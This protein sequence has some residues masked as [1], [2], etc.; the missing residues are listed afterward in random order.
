MRVIVDFHG[1]V[2][3]SLSHPSCISG[4]IVLPS[5][6]SELYALC[7]ESLNSL[8]RVPNLGSVDGIQPSCTGHKQ[9]TDTWGNGVCWEV[10]SVHVDRAS[11]GTIQEWHKSEP[12]AEIFELLFG[13]RDGAREGIYDAL[14]ALDVFTGIGLFD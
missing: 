10:Y 6:D 4:V 11:T 2:S 14:C 5:I 9:D 3:T 13:S 1:L 7:S 12:Y 8:P